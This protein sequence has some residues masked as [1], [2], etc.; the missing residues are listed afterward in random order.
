MKRRRKCGSNI[1]KRN[2]LQTSGLHTT[3]LIIMDM[4]DGYKKRQKHVYRGENVMP[5]WEA[6][7]GKKNLSIMFVRTMRNMGFLQ[8]WLIKWSKTHVNL[9]SARRRIRVWIIIFQK[10]NAFNL[11]SIRMKLSLRRV[12][13]MVSYVYIIRIKASFFQRITSYPKSLQ[14]FR[15]GF[16]AIQI[17]Y[18]RICNR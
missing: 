10:V 18:K 1:S 7:H 6:R 15:I 16:T 8:R 3:I 11:G 5:R 14:I 12:I 9:W 17:R 2:R 4:L 13:R